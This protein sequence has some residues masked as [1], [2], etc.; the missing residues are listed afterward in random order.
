LIKCPLTKDE[1]DIG[2]CVTIVDACDGAIKE[3]ILGNHILKQE[4]WKE[5][6]RKCKYH[7]N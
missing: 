2:E 3:Q 5:I 7:E 1:I 4:N 6:C